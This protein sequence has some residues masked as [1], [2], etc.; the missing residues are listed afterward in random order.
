MR[1]SSDTGC[2]ICKNS[3]EARSSLAWCLILTALSSIVCQ[4]SCLLS[5]L[6]T[7]ES[8][9]ILRNMT[10]LM[11]AVLDNDIGPIASPVPVPNQNPCHCRG[12]LGRARTR[13]M[14]C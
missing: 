9:G 8:D 4:H 12:C 2:F 11:T 13:T 6:H 3:W 1:F 10:C 14:G 5:I 7:Q